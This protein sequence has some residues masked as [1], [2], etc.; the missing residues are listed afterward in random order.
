MAGINRGGAASFYLG[1]AYYEV[2]ADISVKEGGLVR[3]PVVSSG[4]SVDYTVENVA[5]EVTI[6]ALDGPAVSVAALKR[7]N[8]A[9]LQIRANNG[10]SYL[11]NNAFQVDDPD[12]KVDTGEI[13]G[14]KFSG[15]IPMQE[16]T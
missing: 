2:K 12:I 5:P 9:T 3:K 11:L 6:T 16:I 7:I 13:G 15:S 10:K 8:G 14:L 1:G 4:G